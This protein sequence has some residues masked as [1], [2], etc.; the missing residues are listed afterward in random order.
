MIPKRGRNK[1]KR[2]TEWTKI[3]RFSVAFDRLSRSSTGEMRNA[4]DRTGYRGREIL[5]SV[6][7][8]ALFRHLQA[9]RAERKQRRQMRRLPEGDARDGFD[10]RSCLHADPPARGCMKSRGKRVAIG[11]MF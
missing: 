5:L 4:A 1:L 10:Q 9:G 6:V 11:V 3:N 2:Y 8:G 7:R